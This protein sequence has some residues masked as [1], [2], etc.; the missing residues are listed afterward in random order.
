M[1][2]RA[3]KRVEPRQTSESGLA[4][5]AVEP[6]EHAAPHVELTEDE[7]V[8]EHSRRRVELDGLRERGGEHRVDHRDVGRL[9][10]G[11]ALHLLLDCGRGEIARHAR[12]ECALRIAVDL[13]VGAR[14]L[15]GAEAGG[16]DPRNHFGPPGE[17]DRMA[18]L[19]KRARYAEARRQ[20]AAARP[21]EP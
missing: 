1:R 9:G 4:T 6:R 21:V 17:G 12:E 7:R 14:E 10:G 8:H 11:D 20:V 16:L 13:L 18:A 2:S 5:L 19:L 15:D 3:P